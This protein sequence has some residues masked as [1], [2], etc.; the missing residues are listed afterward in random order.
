MQRSLLGS[1]DLNVSQICLGCWQFNGGK[2]DETWPAQSIKVSQSIVD[3]AIEMG[4]NFFDTAEAYGMH[5]SE[6]VLGQCLGSRRRDVII[7]SKFGARVKT[8]YRATDIEES[9]RLSL[10]ALKTDYIDLYQVHWSVMMNDAKETV[11]E[12][13]RL[14]AKGQIKHYG[15]CN[16][17]VQDMKDF[18]DAGGTAVTN[19]LAY[20]LLFRP[21]ECDIIPA[22]VD[23]N[24]SVLAYSPL[25]QGLLTGKFSKPEDVPE[26]RRR[27]RHFSK[28]S[29]TLSKHGQDGAEELTFKSIE[30]I[31]KACEEESVLMATASLSWLLKQQNVAS[32][33][34]GCS[35]ADQ[36]EQ[37]CKLVQVSQEFN[38]KLIEATDELKNVF[39]NNP[40]MWAPTSRIH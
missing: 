27:T 30:S 3:K 17:G 35:S 8:P 23:N 22:C 14:Q 39:G 7:A 19:Q 38:K 13:K 15:V 40:D 28:D 33:I 32:V 37:N 26:G 29:T 1:S 10:E 2:S 5:K 31:R 20:N 6:E 9:L 12:L 16:F 36:L 21:I 11:A 25:Q 34:V 24:T 18:K 4:V